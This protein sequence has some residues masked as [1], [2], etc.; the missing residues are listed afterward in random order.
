M[1]GG[2]VV[3]RDLYL[4]LHQP[5]PQGPGR[6]QRW[7]WGQK[8]RWGDRRWRGNKRTPLPPSPPPPPPLSPLPNPLVPPGASE[9]FS[10]EAQGSLGEAVSH[11]HS[12][13][14]PHPLLLWPQPP[15]PLQ[16]TACPALSL[17]GPLLDPGSLLLRVASSPHSSGCPVIRSAISYFLPA[18]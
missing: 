8:G 2:L 13:N 5:G 12:L 4:R 14:H 15:Q 11:G 9:L 16:S 18:A 6:G 7:G 1:P 3:K 10:L 17:Q